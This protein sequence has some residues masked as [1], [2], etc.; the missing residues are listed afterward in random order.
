MA[1]IRL[2]SMLGNTTVL[3]ALAASECDFAGLDA[4][5]GVIGVRGGEGARRRSATSRCAG[6]SRDR[7]GDVERG[8][9]FAHRLDFR[10]GTTL[11]SMVWH[12]AELEETVRRG[13]LQPTERT[14]VVSERFNGRGVG[15][16]DQRPEGA[17]GRISGMLETRE[18]AGRLAEIVARGAR[19][20]IRRSLRPRPV[21]RD[22][23]R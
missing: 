23:A 16:R 8:P 7:A 17:E 13:R 3:G 9:L 18:A 19:R 21:L 12:P 6:G 11:V 5:C 10:A 14:G 20:P 15:L 2:W 1:K 4:P 22:G